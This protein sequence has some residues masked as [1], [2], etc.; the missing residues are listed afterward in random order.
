MPDE[1]QEGY[2]FIKLFS[3]IKAIIAHFRPFQE[4]FLIVV[5][6]EFTN[7][8]QF[9]IRQNA[10]L[11]YDGITIS[12]YKKLGKPDSVK[13][14]SLSCTCIASTIQWEVK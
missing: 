2:T 5:F 14:L 10:L 3:T 4:H 9:F 1:E 6:Y 12:H 7:D 11:F 13:R 8:S